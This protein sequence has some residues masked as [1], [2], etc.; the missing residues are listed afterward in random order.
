ML[1]MYH[2]GPKK[3]YHDII[4]GYSLNMFWPDLFSLNLLP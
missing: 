2:D 4:V 1:V 3:V